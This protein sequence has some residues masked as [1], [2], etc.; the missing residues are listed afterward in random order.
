MSMRKELDRSFHYFNYS[1]AFLPI[2]LSMW[3]LLAVVVPHP[4]SRKAASVRRAIICCLP[5]GRTPSPPPSKEGGS[6][7]LLSETFQAHISSH[8]LAGRAAAS[9]VSTDFSFS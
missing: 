6:L 4:F 3:A 2:C 9:P 8:F 7:G 1:F 5:G